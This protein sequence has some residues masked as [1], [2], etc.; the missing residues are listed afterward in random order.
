[1]KKIWIMD[2]PTL[3]YIYSWFFMRRNGQNLCS[4]CTRVNDNKCCCLIFFYVENHVVLKSF[5]SYMNE[6]YN[7]RGKKLQ[8]KI[9]KYLAWHVRMWNEIMKIINLKKKKKNCNND[10]DTNYMEDTGCKKMWHRY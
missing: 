6:K 10:I 9:K 4:T 5:E 7:A 3:I 2:F 1:M 8:C